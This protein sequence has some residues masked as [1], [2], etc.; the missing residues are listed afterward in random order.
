MDQQFSDDRSAFDPS[1]HEP[2]ESPTSQEELQRRKQA[3]EKHYTTVEVLA[4]L[5]KLGSGSE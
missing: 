1:Q 4:H 5:E 2:C 3:N